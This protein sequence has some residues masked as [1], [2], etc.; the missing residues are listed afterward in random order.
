MKK[1]SRDL[2]QHQVLP[3]NKKLFANCYVFMITIPNILVRSL[4]IISKIED[5]IK[6]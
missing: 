5:I 1:T 3:F 6:L 2:A 4:E